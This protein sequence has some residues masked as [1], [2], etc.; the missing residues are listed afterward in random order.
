ML[1]KGKFSVHFKVD[2]IKFIEDFIL[3]YRTEETFM[4]STSLCYKNAIEQIYKVLK[5]RCVEIKHIYYL[6]DYE[7]I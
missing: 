1:L 5:T 3:N 6:T 7:E 4:H 2:N